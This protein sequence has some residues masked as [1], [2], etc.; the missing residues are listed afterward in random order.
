M[1]DE[2]EAKVR[3]E[4][5][6]LGNFIN[7]YLPD[8]FG[9]VLMIFKLGENEKLNYLSNCNRRDVILALKEFIAKTERGWAKDMEEGEFG[10]GKHK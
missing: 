2:Q 8:K 7:S 10:V 4:M 3:A 5:Q 6:E 9:F 1:T